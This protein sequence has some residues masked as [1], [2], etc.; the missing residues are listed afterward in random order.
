MALVLGALLAACAAPTP[1]PTPQ[2]PTPTPEPTATPTPTPTPPPP[3]PTPTLSPQQVISMAEPALVYLKAGGNAWNGV[4]VGNGL[5]L[6]TSTNLGMAPVA[7]FKTEA[8]VSGQAWVV[9]RD[10]N[11]DLALLQVVNNNGNLPF[12]KVDPL[13]APAVGDDLILLQFTAGGASVDAR[14][15][16][17]IGVRQDLSS[18]IQFIQVQAQSGT[19]AEGAVLI[20]QQGHLRGIRMAESHMI[21]IGLGQTGEVYGASAQALANLVIPRLQSGVV[22]VQQPGSGSGT[23]N[24][25]P[26]LPAIFQGNA[27]FNGAPLASGKR[28]YVHLSKSGLPDLWFSDE[29]TTSGKYTLVA[30]PFTS[31]YDGASVEFW[32]DATKATQTS[33]YQAGGNN[34]LDLTFG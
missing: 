23:P 14:T 24:S 33:T 32:V 11:L 31:G 17:V 29:V 26:P 27:T 4:M 15:A 22:V 10:D 1:T 28:V 3:T 21:A 13:S 5:I 6:T 12:L 2:P 34:A 18:G 8:G 19:G 16:R 20:D 30:A 9:G 25:P 7:D